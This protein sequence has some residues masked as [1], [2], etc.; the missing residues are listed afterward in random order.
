M[1][2]LPKRR[3]H[4]VDLVAATEA[5]E[6]AERDLREVR[7]RR[8]LVDKLVAELTAARQENNF[9]ARIRAAYGEGR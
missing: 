9:A 7:A 5:L 3:R 8:P 2:W 1:I 6:R 4:E